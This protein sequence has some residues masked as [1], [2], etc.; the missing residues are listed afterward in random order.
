MTEQAFL[1]R[2]RAIWAVVVAVLVLAAVPWVRHQVLLS[3]V[4]Q[5]EPYTAL[6]FLDPARP[7][8][9]ARGTTVVAVTNHEGGRRTYTYTASVIRSGHSPALSHGRVTVANDAT[10]S[11]TI[12]I[13]SRFDTA[14]KNYTLAVALDGRG[15]QVQAHCSKGTS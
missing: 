3:V 8:D 12:G 13:D 15:E 1:I 9:C 4:R 7:I 11:A 6:A 10:S 5:P 14:I 2:P